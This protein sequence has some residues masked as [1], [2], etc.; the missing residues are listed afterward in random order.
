MLRVVWATD[1]SSNSV[2]LSLMT[3]VRLHA[4]VT[5]C[6]GFE[7]RAVPIDLN[8]ARPV[9]NFAEQYRVLT[10]CSDCS[11]SKDCTVGCC[12]SPHVTLQ[13]RLLVLEGPCTD[14]WLQMILKT[15]RLN[16]RG[17]EDQRFIPAALRVS[18]V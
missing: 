1:L 8:A 11:R 4:I 5:A 7:L 15:D 9:Y 6:L 12:L 16:K 2:W 10:S 18:M 17:H 3:A 14:S 13:L